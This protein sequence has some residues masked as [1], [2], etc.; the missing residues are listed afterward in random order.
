MKV[1][2]VNAGLEKGGGLFHI[3]NLLTEAKKEGQDFELLT[4]AEGPVSQKAIS[5][6]IK[7]HVLKTKS[8][9]DL[10]SLKR[11]SQFINE[12]NFDYVHTHGAR[13]NLYLSL[14]KKR[15]NA[16]WVI[17]VHS[18]PL[19]DFEGRG[20]MGWI[21][22]KLN[23][24]A[25]KK[26][27]G[28]LAITQNFANL[29]TEKIGINKK[30]V[31]IIYNGIFFHESSDLP[32]KYDHPYFNLVNVARCEKVKG[33]ELL[34]KA[35]KDLHDPHIRLHIAGDGSELENLKNLAQ[36]LNISNQVT[37]HGF[38]SHDDLSHLYERCDL[39]VLTSYSESFPLVLLEAAD[40]MVP[41]LSTDVG[42]IKKMIPSADYGFVSPI[43]DLD[44]IKEQILKASLMPSI[45]LREMAKRE[46]EYLMNN[47]SLANQ[48]E[49]ILQA[50]TKIKNEA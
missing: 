15:I 27:D 3:I 4:L 45:E 2:H 31:H 28:I 35:L 25:L 40:N 24:K 14:I 33:Q 36:E 49:M 12:N 19:L 47:F 50:Y 21:F 16:K 38:M 48:L 22:T 30:K 39:A 10:T 7:T 5:K 41:L 8:R 42:D 34:L 20:F 29:L 32:A 11:L 23:I 6:G 43:G 18:N 9:Y 37:F 44:M 1:L 26:A 17:T 46:K 13:A